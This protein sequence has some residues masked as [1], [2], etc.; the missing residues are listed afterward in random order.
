MK[1][2]RRVI[3]N[4]ISIGHF[5]SLNNKLIFKLAANFDVKLSYDSCNAIL[6]TLK[7]LNTSYAVYKFDIKITPLKLSNKISAVDYN[8]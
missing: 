5:E 3:I 1:Y 7:I 8:S 2:F 6:R 4:I